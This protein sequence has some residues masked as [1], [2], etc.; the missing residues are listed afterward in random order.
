METRE[1]R[2]EQE[3]RALHREK[4]RLR[5]RLQ[6]WPTFNLPP[7]CCVCV[8][9]LPS[10]SSNHRPTER[11]TKLCQTSA[12]CVCVS[13]KLTHSPHLPTFTRRRRQHQQ[14][15]Q[16]QHTHTAHTTGRGAG[17]KV[18]V[19]TERE[20]ASEQEGCKHYL[21]RLQWNFAKLLVVGLLCCSRFACLLM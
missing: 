8:S 1:E 16:Q 6:R 15:Q 11:P 13:S 4:E 19:A 18:Q 7:A 2:R 10:S 5:H 17:T 14:Q 12:R 9:R 21:T 20:L 3:E